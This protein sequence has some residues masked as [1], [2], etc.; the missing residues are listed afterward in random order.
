MLRLGLLVALSSTALHTSAAE[1][2]A[3]ES[4]PTTRSGVRVHLMGELGRDTKLA[5]LLTEWLGAN[6][7]R[8][9]VVHQVELRLEDI[10]APRGSGPEVRVWVVAVGSRQARLYFAEP[11]AQRYLVREVPLA[12]GFD[13]VGREQIV[14][15]VLASTL[16]FMDRAADSS[17]AELEEAMPPRVESVAASEPE[18]PPSTVPA[19]VPTGTAGVAEP[20]DRVA[21]GMA[22][23][24]HHEWATGVGLSVL[25]GASDKGEEGVAHGPGVSVELGHGNEAFGLALRLHGQYRFDRQVSTDRVQLSV[26]E[27]VAAGSAVLRVQPG[28]PLCWRAEVGAGAQLLRI[29]P[30]A[31]TDDV[32]ARSAAHDERP[33]VLV[34]VGPA[35]E[36]H[37]GWIRLMARL[38]LQLT[39]TRYDVRGESGAESELAV[40]RAQPGMFVEVGGEPIRF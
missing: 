23:A 40:K 31:R 17:L 13:E 10:K 21:G 20:R 32:R 37:G 15:V 27:G 29:E 22:P 9:E 24:A 34:A 25:Y 11:D 26:R 33:F 7:V 14:Q 5:Q 28:G 16:A 3:P 38:D 6:D 30:H 39:R 4:V 12:S 19:R 1:D 8:H 36:A 35:W 2:I 18:A